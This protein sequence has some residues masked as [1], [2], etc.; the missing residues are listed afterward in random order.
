MAVTDLASTP[1]SSF[2]S[3]PPARRVSTELAI[4]AGFRQGTEGASVF[5]RPMWDDG[6]G[7]P[8]DLDRDLSPIALF[9]RFFDDTMLDHCVRKTNEYAERHNIRWC[10]GGHVVSV[11]RAR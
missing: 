2:S 10:R 5:N 8:K 1:T 9:R 11:D 3:S 4:P 6:I 7:G